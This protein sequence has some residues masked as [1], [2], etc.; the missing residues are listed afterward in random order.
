MFKRIFLLLLAAASAHA[1]DPGLSSAKLKI[2]SGHVDATLTFAPADI[3]AITSADVSPPASLRAIAA[4]SLEIWMNGQAVSP[5]ETSVRVLPN[6]DVEFELVFPT[7]AAAPLKAR[8][9]LLDRLPFGHRQYFVVTDAAGAVLAEKLL[10]GADEVVTATPTA[11]PVAPAHPFSEFVGMGVKHILTG[12][13]HLLFLLAL[14]MGC[15]RLS[16]IVKIITAF[17]V[18]HSISLALATLGW[19][20]V[21]SRIVEPLIAATIVYVAVENLVRGQAVAHRVLLTFGFGLVHGFGFASALREMG[22]GSHGSAVAVPLIGFNS[23]VEIG[24]MLVA[25]VILPII[26]HLKDRPQFA[27]RWAPACSMMV[28]LA[29]SFWFLQ[30]VLVN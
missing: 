14:L 26:W 25:A 15:R 28:A 3:E 27:A 13:D 5:T 18:A 2:A 1:H 19:V 7:T 8:S 10:R 11:I 23:G 17:T 6:K 20:E 16:S 30:R 9:T 12:Y 24:Q 29:G 22:V 4:Q 21:P